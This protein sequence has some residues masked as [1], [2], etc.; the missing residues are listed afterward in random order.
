MDIIRDISAA[1]GD[2]AIQISGFHTIDA[3]MFI[4]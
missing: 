3:S 1:S 2:A 4:F